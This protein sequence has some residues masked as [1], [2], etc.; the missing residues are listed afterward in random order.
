MACGIVEPGQEL[1]NEIDGGNVRIEFS[2]QYQRRGAGPAADVRDLQICR[3]LQ[4]R[5]RN[6]ETRFVVSTRT[7][8]QAVPVQIEQ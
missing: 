8:A 5:K 3:S 4:T 2:G 1:R 6:G 7:L